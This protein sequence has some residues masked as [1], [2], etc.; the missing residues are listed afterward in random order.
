MD[1]NR[2]NLASFLKQSGYDT[3]LFGKWHLGARWV[4]VPEPEEKQGAK[5]FGSWKVDYTQPFRNGPTD[6]GFDDAFS[7]SLRS[8]CRPTSTFAETRRL[9]CRRWIVDST[10]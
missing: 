4:T 8:T 7:F 5:T 2:L 6:L 3:A 10:Q 9:K 1:P